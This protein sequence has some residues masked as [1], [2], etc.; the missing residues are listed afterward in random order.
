MW[1][2]ID[3]V[4]AEIVKRVEAFGYKLSLPGKDKTLLQELQAIPGLKNEKI[5]FEY[6]TEF[7]TLR[8]TVNG[9]EALTHDVP[10]VVD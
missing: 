9:Q 1:K 2:L 4:R 7:K 10:I 6:S 8:V 5:S 3:E